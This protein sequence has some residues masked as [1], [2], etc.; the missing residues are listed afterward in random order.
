MVPQLLHWRGSPV[1]A[2]P[3]KR[4]RPSASALLVIEC[5]TERLRTDGLAIGQPICDLLGSFHP[6]AKIHLVQTSTLSEAHRSLGDAAQRHG[7]FRLA[8]V[9]GHS[10]ENGIQWTRDKFLMWPQVGAWLKFFEPSGVF[11]TACDAGR[12][13]VVRQLFGA[14]PNL[15][16]VYGSPTKLAVHQNHPLVMC[17]LDELGRY[18]LSP[19]GRQIIQAINLL[20]TRGV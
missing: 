7:R 8:F 14:M 15:K 5:D 9:I 6:P 4:R 3:A 13:P 18:G 1:A 16:R 17:A 11:L 20:L 19:D 12:L 2:K 10:N